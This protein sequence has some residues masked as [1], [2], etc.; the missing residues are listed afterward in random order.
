MPTGTG[1]ADPKVEI[2]VL[3]PDMSLP[4]IFIGEDF[5][6]SRKVKDAN[7]RSLVYRIDMPLKQYTISE[8]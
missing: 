6:A 8:W 3:C 7:E 1:R 5:V 2:Q 4:F